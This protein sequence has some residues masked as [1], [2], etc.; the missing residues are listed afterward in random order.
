ML[1][2]ATSAISADIEVTLIS[3]CRSLSITMISVSHRPQL[4]RLHS[5]AIVLD[6]AVSIIRIDLLAPPS[7]SRA[8][9]SLCRYNT[10]GR[11]DTE[12]KSLK[13]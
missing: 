2:E 7:T 12:L 10:L 3:R 1:D 5:Y 9:I 11:E 6:G 4:R 13:E 8:L